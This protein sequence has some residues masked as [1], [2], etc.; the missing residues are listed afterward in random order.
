MTYKKAPSCG[1]FRPALHCPE[2]EAMKPHASGKWAE[3]M[4]ND[5]AWIWQ[6]K[7]P[8]L[9]SFPTQGTS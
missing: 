5:A 9:Q 6:T 3:R 1:C 4:Q 7:A 2:P 8:G